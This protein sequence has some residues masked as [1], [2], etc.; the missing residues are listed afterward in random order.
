MAKELTELHI[1]RLKKIVLD[2]L[3]GE[4]LDLIQLR[5]QKESSK[6]KLGCKALYEL[7]PLRT[8]SSVA[9]LSNPFIPAI[10]G[11]R[12]R[13][14][15]YDDLLSNYNNLHELLRGLFSQGDR[16]LESLLD[17]IANTKPNT[18]W[19]LIFL[20]GALISAGVGGVAYIKSD[21]IEAIG[22]WF[23]K[24][25]PLV[26]QWISKT[27]SLLRNFHL[28]AAILN[29]LMLTWDWYQTLTSYKKTNTEKLNLFLFQTLAATLTISAYIIC[30][31]AGGTATLAAISLFVASAA[32]NFFQG[33]FN[34][35]KSTS[36][37]ESLIPTPPIA[38]APWEVRAQY[39]REMSFH[40]RDKRSAWVKIA[41][42][43]LTTLSVGIWYSFPLSYVVSACFMSFNFLIALAEQSLTNRIGE[44][45][46]HALQTSI[47]A[48]TTLR[49][50]ALSP[51]NQDDQEKLLLK[52]RI[53]K[54]E[55]QVF[56]QGV[57]ENKRWVEKTT[58]QLHATDKKIKQGERQLQEQKELLDLK[59]TELSSREN[60]LLLQ[61]QLISKLAKD[62]RR[63]AS[64]LHDVEPSEDTLN[65]TPSPSES[66]VG[67]E[68]YAQFFNTKKAKNSTVPQPLSLAQN[69]R[70]SSSRIA[71]A[72]TAPSQSFFL[73][74]TLPSAQQGISLQKS[75]HRTE[76][77]SLPRTGRGETERVS[78]LD[79]SM[80]EVMHTPM[81]VSLETHT[82]L[83]GRS[84]RPQ[85]PSLRDHSANDAV[86]EP[87]R[88]D[89]TQPPPEVID[90]LNATA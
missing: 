9:A 42:A 70:P 11:S 18:D 45:A 34:L 59:A 46:N 54:R 38:E 85:S 62:L 87:V 12:N 2:Y 61:K 65:P 22:A 20:M 50:A 43:L 79:P 37:L 63:V 48:I 7:I 32:T 73:P 72:M 35:W 19:T 89:L 88:E 27:F 41:T 82:P 74:G 81:D 86:L 3:Q 44:H 25:F 90:S 15:P 53:F 68:E 29:G 40:V 51:A 13:Q 64:V 71:S 26:I 14:G 67:R 17:M 6:S 57:Q 30:F 16:H 69:T 84:N 78:L 4:A 76:G 10:L 33:S 1:S 39:E 23:V 52:Q 60:K 36:A 80:E 28:L 58:Q 31:F 77:A 55:Q 75:V 24:T 66:E 8:P 21:T 56:E 47:D 83:N 5:L 49:S